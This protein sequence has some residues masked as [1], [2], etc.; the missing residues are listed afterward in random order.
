MISRFFLLI[1]LL[2]L[3]LD[4]P[5]LVKTKLTDDITASIPKG[6]VPMTD[7]DFTERYPSVRAPLAAYTNDER[8]ADFSVNISATQW[9]DADL[10][11][12]QKFFKASIMNMFD[13]VQFISEGIRE[14][15][16]KK[17]V[18]FEFESRV[19]G[20]RNQEGNADPV[21]GY[22]HQQYLITPKRTL[23]FTF[24]CPRRI[25]NQWESTGLAIMKSLKVN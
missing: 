11:I 21:L 9:P 13:K 18:Y 25:R 20:N 5:K 23:V 2:L 10:V 1:P 22:T 14:V 17:Y 16:G 4:Q 3:S 7:L 19:H 15:G 12:A 24:N 8:S 6:W